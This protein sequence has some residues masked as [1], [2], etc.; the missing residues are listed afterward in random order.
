MAA[1]Y[2]GQLEHLIR[3]EMPWGKANARV[4]WTGVGVDRGKLRQLREGCERK[5]EGVL[6]EP[7]DHGIQNP[8]SH[9][10]LAHCFKAAGLLSK[11]QKAGGYTF[12]DEHLKRHQEDHPVI[13]LI[14]KARKLR[15]MASN[16]LIKGELVGADGRV[17]AQ[18]NQLGTDSGRQSTRPRLWYRGGRLV[19]D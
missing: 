12:D 16:P 4:E 8:N 3:L 10:Q 17:R 18:H 6:Q 2:A 19:P 5:L 13:P 14:R 11:F 15:R 1:T 9:P 7:A